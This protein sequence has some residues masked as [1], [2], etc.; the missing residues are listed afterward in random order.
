M[1]PGPVAFFFF[2]LIVCERATV[3][4]TLTHVD[5]LVCEAG[6]IVTPLVYMFVFVCVCVQQVDCRE[7]DP[8]HLL[9]WLYGFSQG[10]PEKTR[11]SLLVL[12]M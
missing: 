10:T 5:H 2:P 8:S 7:C 12:P 4:A 9:A 3:A 6:Q 1:A 11:G